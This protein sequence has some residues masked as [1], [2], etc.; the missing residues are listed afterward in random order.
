MKLF[1]Y[2]FLFTIGRVVVIFLNLHVY[3]SLVVFNYICFYRA[4]LPLFKSLIDFKTRTMMRLLYEN[5]TLMVL[6][7]YVPLLYGKTPDI[8][9]THS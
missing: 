2:I 1:V 5:T 7:K 8:N 4:G 6:Q 9:S 3:T